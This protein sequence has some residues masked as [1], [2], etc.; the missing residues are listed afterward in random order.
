MIS[1]VDLEIAKI[2]QALK[3][4]GKDKNTV[5]ILMGDNGYFLGERQIADKWMMYDLPIRI[6]LIIYDPRVQKHLDVEA[7]ALNLDVPSTIVDLAGVAQPK[8]WHG[9][10]LLPIVT[11]KSDNVQRDTILIEHLWE[12]ESI[13]PSEGV[14]TPEWKYFRY[15][16]DKTLEEL[17]NLKKDPKEIENLAKRAEY[18]NKL[19]ELR[20]KLDALAQKYADPY[21]GI[22]SGLTVEYIREPKNVAIGSRLP[23]YSWIVPKEAVYQNAFQ[24]LVAS[25]KTNI[26]NNLGD[27]W[28]SGQIRSKVST[29]IEQ[30]GKPLQPNSTYFWKVRIWDQDNRLSDYSVVQEFKTSSFAETVSTANAFQIERISPK[31]ISK[32]ATNSYLVDF[33]KD[34]FG[35][36]ELTYSGTKS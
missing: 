13:P 31:T 21:S 1:G 14:R 24:I 15:V 18:L 5:I 23:E 2:R 28:N 3:V 27:V 8:S 7:M 22:P 16:N 9:K 26:D 32:T 12:M 34:A 30:T 19:K 11:G 33:G 36:L 20:T 25:S 35:T 6:P 4:K 17:Y 10:S 29:N